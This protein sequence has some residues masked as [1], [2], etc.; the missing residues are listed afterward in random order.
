MHSAKYDRKHLTWISLILDE[1]QMSDALSLTLSDLP[2]VA[3]GGLFSDKTIL[4]S[5]AGDFQ[6]VGS[7]IGESFYALLDECSD[8]EL[9][10]VLRLQGA[11]QTGS[12]LHVR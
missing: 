1:A 2:P 3:R 12:P 8:Q 4:E 7:D 9:E 10:E 11:A 5:I 6:A